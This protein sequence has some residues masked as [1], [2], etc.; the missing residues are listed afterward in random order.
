MNADYRFEIV[1]YW[2]ETDRS[3]IA[4]VPDL[5]GCRGDGPTHAEA[6]RHVE[7]VIDQWIETAR[8]LG[9]EIP[10]PRGRLLHA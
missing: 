8:A 6:L 7:L 9:R 5:A 1:I 2:S 3:F 10:R 4:E